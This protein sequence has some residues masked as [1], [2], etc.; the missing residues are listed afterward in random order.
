MLNS[1]L[2]RVIIKSAQRMQVKK[3][4]AVSG[5]SSIMI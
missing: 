1:C 2:Y 4:R 3:L 5:D